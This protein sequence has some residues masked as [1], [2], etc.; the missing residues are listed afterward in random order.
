MFLI[1][2]VFCVFFTFLRSKNINKIGA[3][4][5]IVFVHIFLNHIKKPLKIKIKSKVLSFIGRANK[6]K[7]IINI[8][9]YVFVLKY[10]CIYINNH[11]EISRKKFW[12]AQ[13]IFYYC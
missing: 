2:C 8:Y 3:I 10:I 1:E 5:I 12:Q 4:I 6:V 13:N 9:T 11:F 7:D